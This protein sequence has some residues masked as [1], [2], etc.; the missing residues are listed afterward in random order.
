LT[1]KEQISLKFSQKF[2]YK[3]SLTGVSIQIG[4]RKS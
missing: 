2:I 4:P 1:V 3:D